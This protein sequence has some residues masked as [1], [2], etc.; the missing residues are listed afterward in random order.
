MI[1]NSLVVASI[2]ALLAL[3]HPPAAAAHTNFSLAIG[4]PFFGATV[5]VPGPYYAPPYGP[6]AYLPA[7]VYVPAPVY[8]PAPVYVG[9]VYYGPRRVFVPAYR[10]YRVRAYHGP[11]GYRHW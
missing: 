9:P 10:P 5:A 8:A 11:H 3:V 1:K 7:P 2:T 4:I 6:P